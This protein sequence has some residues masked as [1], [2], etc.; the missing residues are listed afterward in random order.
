[1]AR[2]YADEDFSFPV[3]EL[4]RVFGHDVD[5]ALDAGF[6]NQKL[7]DTSVLAFATSERRC[8]LTF[9]RRD[10]I[11]LHRHSAQHSGIIVCTR[12]DDC[13]AL[14]ARIHQLLATTVDLEQQLFRV[15]RPS[16]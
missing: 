15:N 2:L 1:M 10:F 14:A 4:L 5:T 3:V 6:A 11:R 12:D 16:A 8:V 7:P 9:N 13:V